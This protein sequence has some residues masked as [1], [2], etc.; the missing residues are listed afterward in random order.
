MGNYRFEAIG[1]TWRQ[2]FAGVLDGKGHT[3]RGL[4]VNGSLDKYA[5]LFG[6]CDTVSVLKNIVLEKPV[7]TSDYYYAG[8][9]VSWTLG[10]I[11]NITVNSPEVTNTSRIVAAGVAGI[12]NRADNCH[13]TNGV[14]SGAGYVGGVAGEV[15]GGIFNSSAT[16]TTVYALS[17]IHI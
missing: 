10:D 5:G 6:M 2:R 9:L 13:V 12:V 4:N 11:E 1:S 14:I 16:N 17:L 7:I 8:S 3:I 15:H